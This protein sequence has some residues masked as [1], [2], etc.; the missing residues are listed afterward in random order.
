[1]NPSKDLVGILEQAEYEFRQQVSEEKSTLRNIPID[2]I[3]NTQRSS[4]CGRT[5]FCPLG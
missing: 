3:C 1:V 2:E 5:L 4:H